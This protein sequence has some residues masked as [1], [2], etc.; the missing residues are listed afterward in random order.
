MLKKENKF[1][2]T[3]YDT[4]FRP[5]VVFCIIV[6]GIAFSCIQIALIN[7]KQL[8]AVSDINTSKTILVGESRG[9]I[10]DTDMRRLV[11]NDYSYICALTPD[12]NSLTKI[13]GFVDENE[14]NNAVNYIS[15]QNPILLKTKQYIN[16]DRI[17]CEK[18]YK[19]YNDYQI[20]AHLIGYTDSSCRKGLAGFEHAYDKFLIQQSGFCKARFFINGNGSVM[21]GG[22][23]EKIEDNFNSS[24]GAVL[25]I[26]KRFQ[27][28]LEKAMDN[29]SFEKGAAVLIDIK[30]GAI[31]A[32]VSR[33][34]FNPNKIDEYI[35]D[36]DSALFNRAFGAYPI[37]SVFKP[38]VAVSALEQG[39]DPDEEIFCDGKITVNSVS[40]GCTESHGKVNMSTALAYSCNCYFVNLIEKIDCT[41]VIDLAQ[42]LGFGNAVII[43][44]NLKTYSGY[45]PDISELDSSAARANFSFGQGK[46]TATPYQI[47]ML[48][49]LISNGGEYY[50]PYLLKGFCNDEGKFESAEDFS[51]PVKL[52]SFETADILKQ[53]LELAVRE[54]TGKAAALP[55]MQVAGKTSTA[56]SGEF[57]NGKE[58][59]VTWFAGFFPYENPEYVAVIVCEDGISGAKDC[60][61]VFS[62]IANEVIRLKY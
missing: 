31:K 60:A 43:A 48:Y 23:I 46:L 2:N 57:V 34:N 36:T 9:V 32:S 1:K 8:N 6:F 41:Q 19:R 25:T 14:Y 26:D 53:Y 30:T 59:L 24:G 27:T 21:L 5:I 29:G 47:A 4:D 54:G 51:Y 18:I 61:P 37:G 17:V 56:Q 13:R 45:L 58:R 38:L 49:C 16:D 15:N 52:I 42:S 33:P 7:I 11:C 20:A 10:Y 35:N 40:F 3:N 62:K 44:D 28:A 55:G 39:I 50:K 12:I 22:K